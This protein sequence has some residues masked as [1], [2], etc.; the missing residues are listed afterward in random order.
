MAS[1]LKIKIQNQKTY[2]KSKSVIIAKITL[3]SN[4]VNI[5][6]LILLLNFLSYLK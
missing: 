2:S 4:Y 6:L 3:L 5:K 1:L